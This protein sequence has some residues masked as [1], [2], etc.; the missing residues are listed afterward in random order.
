M[1]EKKRQRP[2]TSVVTGKNTRLS[3]V[4]LLAPRANEGEKPKYSTLLLIPKEDT[5]TLEAIQKAA[6]AA[7]NDGIAK[8]YWPKTAKLDK[9]W[10][11]LK[12]GDED[13][14]IEDRPELAGH[15][16]MNVSSATP[17]GIVDRAMSELTDERDVYS[18]MFA[19]VSINAFAYKN[20]Q[21]KGVSFALNNVMKIRDG[22]RFGGNVS[23]ETDFAD[24]AEDF[25]DEDEDGLL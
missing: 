15:M 6:E 11:T 24:F 22:E 16:A 25:D 20:T 14:N 3:Y 10:Q 9:Y 8:G 17:P 5:E 2:V 12:D 23:A 4:H 18:G 21:K 13:E 1:A 19:R 7:F